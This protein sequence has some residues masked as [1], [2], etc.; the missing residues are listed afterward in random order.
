MTK[1]NVVQPYLLTFENRK[2]YL[3]A[4][5]DG[6]LDS[7][8]I[9]LQ[10]WSRVAA[11]CERSGFSKVLVVEAL[12]KNLLLPDAFRTSC[13]FRHEDFLGLKIAFVDL[14]DE[15]AAVNDFNINMSTR[16][17]VNI[18]SFPGV[19]EAENWLL[20]DEAATLKV[21]VAARC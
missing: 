8:A 17:G 4:R 14:Y 9:S 16:R 18:R 12:A 15:H 3:L 1:P 10:Y 20:D 21:T 19:K 13:A 7:P 2:K 11:V 6:E 5:V